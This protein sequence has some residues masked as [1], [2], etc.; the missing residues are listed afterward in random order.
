M[1]FAFML[2]PT[3]GLFFIIINVAWVIFGRACLQEAVREG[4][5][6]AITGQ[7]L[8][9]DTTFA[10]SV[11]TVTQEH[12]FGF[13]PKACQVTVQFFSSSNLS[14]VTNPAGGDVVEVSV[15]NI[16]V[17]PLAALLISSAAIPLSASEADIMQSPQGTQLQAST[18]CQP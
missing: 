17:K 1:E 6:Y 10:S 13:I 2:L 3:L 12:S 16:D 14:S 8:S 18:P 4:V 7:A 5:R 15:A 9:G 11:Q